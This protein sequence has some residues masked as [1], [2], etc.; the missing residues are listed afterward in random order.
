MRLYWPLLIFLLWSH[1][2][3]AQTQEPAMPTIAL[4]Q[5]REALLV[6]RQVQYLED[7]TGQLGIGDI[8]Q[9]GWQQK[10]RATG[11]TVFTT[12]PTKSAFWFK[13]RVQ[14]QTGQAAMI[15]L[16]NLLLDQAD[17][18]LPQDGRYGLAKRV[19]K[20]LPRD[21]ASP[22]SSYW[23]PIGA[24]HDPTDYY[25]RVTSG[26]L[27][28][29]PVRVGTVPA[30]Y[31]EKAKNDYLVAGFVGALLVMFCYNLF[32]Y[33]SIRERV[34]LWY[35]GYVLTV[36]F[37]AT[38]LNN[39]PLLPSLFGGRAYFW[40]FEYTFAWLGL[41]LVFAGLF[42]V[43][44]LHLAEQPKALRWILYMN[45]YL[46]GLGFPAIN[47]FGLMP[48]HLQTTI[49]QVYT[50]YA[51]TS[52][53]GICYYLWRHGQH[54]NLGFYT[55]GW[56]WAIA[57][58]F[59]YLL[60]MNGLLPYHFTTRNA[61]FLG[62]AIEVWLFSLAL[63]NR[64]NLLRQER[65]LAREKNLVLM[66]EQQA[67]LEEKI[68]ERTAAIARNEQLLE[69]TGQVARIGAWEI[70][71]ATGR[72]TWS[73]VTRQIHEVDDSYV[74]NTVTDQTFHEYGDGPS[75]F[76]AALRQCAKRGT[77]FD[78]EAKIQT[79]Q[80]RRIWVRVLGNA[81]LAEGRPVRLY[82]TFQDIDAQKRN[83][84]E[85][86]EIKDQLAS[87]FDSISEVVWSIRL[88]E[89]EAILITPSAEDLYEIPVPALLANYQLWQSVV[90]PDDREVIGLIENA[91]P[92][93]QNYYYEYR[94]V[95]QSG[96]TKWLG[97]SG[98]LITDEVGNRIRVDGLIADISQRK[99]AEQA[100]AEE[101]RLLR[102]IIDNLPVNIY[103]K[104]LNSR[105]IVANRT[106]Y[107][108][109]GASSEAEV[110]GKDDTELYP[111]E[112]AM[113]SRN[114]DEEVFS[115]GRPIINRETFNIR[116]DGS[117]TWFLISKLPLRNLDGDT[118]GLVG[119]SYD[120]SER[121]LNEEI[122]RQTLEE[123]RA[124]QEALEK[125][126]EEIA[127]LNNHLELL[128]EERTRQLQRR[129]EQ[130]NQYAFFNAHKLRAPIATILGLYQVLKLDIS[131][132]EQLEVVHKLNETVVEL[133]QMVR[134]SQ[135][136]LAEARDE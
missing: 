54:R 94:I 79:A 84:L 31:A 35:L 29:L 67:V 95:T 85:V 64:M 36:M 12:A 40:F 58:V 136:L 6:G 39:Y 92:T 90:H 33:F 65:D 113:A 76:V 97:H 71:L 46:F 73:K 66:R 26:D 89:R 124:A 45:S 103:V 108:Y 42:A 88:P 32:L 27:F 59:V 28:E 9:P 20:L 133:D 129:N 49:Y 123:L 135:R 80:G 110:L 102:T 82:G 23:L 109:L 99:Q 61:V 105:K 48:Y 52:V 77:A 134:Q 5:E 68:E 132:E 47:L 38:Y 41:P 37:T 119:I 120:F 114:E 4:A 130:L 81:E 15:E 50:L 34:Y 62:V 117:K 17:F 1:C 55:L 72:V 63:A 8:L 101:H 53:L 125:Q 104:D 74:P 91:L 19:G 43:D 24:G 111:D 69:Q 106:E 21:P 128:V 93:A 14:N 51:T 22:A 87:V 56:T 107:E 131:L 100:L 70:D 16:G 122:L 25:V 3:T 115:S 118:I 11:A 30:L 121:K 44:F 60:C 18:Y 75:P 7:P 10:F 116:R 57:G 83:E 2:A 112:T 13:L 126:T 86:K 78:V 96:K 98:K 127:N